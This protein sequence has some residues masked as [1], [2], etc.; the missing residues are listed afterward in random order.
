MIASFLIACPMTSF[1]TTLK[2]AACSAYVR[3]FRSCDDHDCLA[4]IANR[5]SRGCRIRGELGVDRLI[6]E[7]AKMVKMMLSTV[8]SGEA[9]LKHNINKINNVQKGYEENSRDDRSG[10]FMGFKGEV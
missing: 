4:I 3:A 6:V 1:F 5:Y 2:T 10:L 8:E 7:V 9:S